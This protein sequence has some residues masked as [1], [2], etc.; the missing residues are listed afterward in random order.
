MPEAVQ[1]FLEAHTEG[2]EIPKPKDERIQK[3]WD[4][5]MGMD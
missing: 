1:T 3:F 2:T 5:L 4:V